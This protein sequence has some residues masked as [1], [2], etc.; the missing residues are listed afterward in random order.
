M[1]M[2]PGRIPHITEEDIANSQSAVRAQQILRYE[3]MWRVVEDRI[4]SDQDDGDNFRPLDPRYLEL[5]VRILKEE[6]A[7]Y[8]LA[9]PAPV[10]EEEGDPQQAAVDRGRLV[11]AQLEDVEAR[12]KAQSELKKEMDVEA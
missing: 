3:A 5:G 12:L 1:T 8:R 2:E 7:L 4:N 10:E 11:L 9:R 6:A